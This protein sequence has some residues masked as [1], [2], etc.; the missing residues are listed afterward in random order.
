MRNKH[1][2]TLEHMRMG[3][4]KGVILDADGSELLNLYEAFEIQPKTINFALATATTD[5][6]KKCLEL[7]RYVEDNLRGEHMTA[8]HALVSPEFFD[9]LTGHAKVKEA[10]ERF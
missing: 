6:K 3:A 7:K 8:L 4:L 2:I 1:A 9:A 10:Y 5:V